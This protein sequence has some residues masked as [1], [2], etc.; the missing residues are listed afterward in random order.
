MDIPEIVRFG[1]YCAGAYLALNIPWYFFKYRM[2]EQGSGD[3]QYWLPLGFDLKF[4]GRKY[5]QPDY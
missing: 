5:S 3:W 2:R 4:A 1:F